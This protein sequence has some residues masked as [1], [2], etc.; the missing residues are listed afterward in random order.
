MEIEAIFELIGFICLFVVLI[1]AAVTD[2]LHRKVYNWL[3]VP[4]M[5]LGLALGYGAG[6]YLGFVDHLQGM[7]FGFGVFWL[8]HLVTGGKAIGLGD[9]K[10]MAGIGALGGLKLTVIA[11]FWGSLVGAV[12]AIWLLLWRGALLR[13]LRRSVIYA[14]SLKRQEEAEE[15]DP[16]KARIPYGV[17]LSFGS[18]L[19]FFLVRLN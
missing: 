12:M 1:T 6:G 11:M 15:D 2:L 16:V 18:M 14:V 7:L 19:A 3:T 17:A 13:G 4:A 10:L 8:M 5:A 9:V